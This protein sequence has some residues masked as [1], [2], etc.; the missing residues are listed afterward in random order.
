M[1][2]SKS[3]HWKVRAWKQQAPALSGSVQVSNYKHRNSNITQ[4]FPFYLHSSPFL[5]AMMIH[6]CIQHIADL[7]NFMTTTWQCKISSFFCYGFCR[8]RFFFTLTHSLFLITIVE[9]SYR[10]KSANLDDRVNFLLFINIKSNQKNCL[11]YWNNIN[12]KDGG[13]L[14]LLC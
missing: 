10:L 13:L 2:M 5:K 9:S 8:F 4:H 11:I 14:Q 12:Q 7:C 6:M 1:S 3:S